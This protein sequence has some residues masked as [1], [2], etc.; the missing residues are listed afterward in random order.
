MRFV[1]LRGKVLTILM[2]AVDIV[3]ENVKGFQLDYED[4]L[5]VTNMLIGNM[6]IVALISMTY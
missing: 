6:I 1:S 4:S 3:S 5:F 2:P